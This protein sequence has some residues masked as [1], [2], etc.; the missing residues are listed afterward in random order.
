MDSRK[1]TGPDKI[2]PKNVKMLADI[3]DS[4]VKLDSNLK[5]NSFSGSAKVAPVYPVF[6]GK[7]ERS[8]IKNYKPVSILNCFS[9]VY[10]RFIHE[11]PTLSAFLYFVF[12]I[13]LPSVTI[14]YDGNTFQRKL[15]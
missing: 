12:K 2:P 8:E 4:F 6:K 10:E 9:N 5:R 13:Y 3:I 14:I 15:T 7:G 11:Q 1:T